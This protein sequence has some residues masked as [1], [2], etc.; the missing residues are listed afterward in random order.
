M[1]AAVADPRLDELAAARGD[2][3]RLYAAAA[4]Q[5]ARSERQRISTRLR[6]RGVTVVDAPPERLPSALA[7]AYLAL[8]GSGRL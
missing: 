6:Q 8:K 5:R 2:A 4:A 7:D 3:P 1:I